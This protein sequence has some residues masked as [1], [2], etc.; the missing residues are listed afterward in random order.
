LKDGGINS[1]AARVLLSEA[2]KTAVLPAGSGKDRLNTAARDQKKQLRQ[3]TRASP[4]EKGWVG[5]K[6]REEEEGGDA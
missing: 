2:G 1:E 6:E 4:M 5:E 3:H